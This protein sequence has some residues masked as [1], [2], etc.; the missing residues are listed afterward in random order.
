MWLNE[1]RQSWFGPRRK[2]RQSRRPAHR[3]NGRRLDVEPLERRALLT[4]TIPTL[5]PSTLPADTAGVSYD[6]VITAS[7]GT[8]TVKL[9][10]N[11]TSAIKGF[12]VPAQR[13]R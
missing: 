2:S 1:L 3:P 8:G 11:V 10:V 4:V 6:Q 5:S 7:G 13:D 12:T 9:A